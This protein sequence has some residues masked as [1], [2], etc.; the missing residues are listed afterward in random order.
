MLPCEWLCL[1][2]CLTVQCTC[3]QHFLSTQIS[4][5]YATI[6]IFTSIWNRLAILFS[7]MHVT[8]YWKNFPDKKSNV[9]V[10]WRTNSTL[11]S[12]LYSIQCNS[13]QKYTEKICSTWP[14]L[15]YCIIYK[16]FFLPSLLHFRSPMPPVN[17]GRLNGEKK[18]FRIRRPTDIYYTWIYTRHSTCVYK[19]R[20]LHNY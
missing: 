3:T 17:L 10:T 20:H 9:E 6:F 16:K 8:F 5:R 1:R 4:V 12:P 7:F 14:V 19:H 15:N 13:I 2:L 11:F 18:T